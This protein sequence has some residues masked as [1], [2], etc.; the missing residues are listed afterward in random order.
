MASHA[1]HSNCT[2]SGCNCVVVMGG[3]APPS[4]D[5]KNGRPARS[6]LVDSAV[7]RPVSDGAAAKSAGATTSWRLSIATASLATVEMTSALIQPHMRNAGAAAAAATTTRSPTG[8]PPSAST[9]C[10]G[11][12]G[13]R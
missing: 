8:S 12:R 13:R 3:P 9:S 1:H 11:R 10:S 7:K 4:I 5:E 6:T 2:F